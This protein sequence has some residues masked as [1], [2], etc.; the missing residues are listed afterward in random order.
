M[1]H[2]HT[3]TPQHISRERRKR[4]VTLP[5]TCSSDNAPFRLKPPTN[6][7]KAHETQ[8]QKAEQ[9]THT[10]HNTLVDQTQREDQPNTKASRTGSFSPRP[11]LALAAAGWTTPGPMPSRSGLLTVG[12]EKGREK[13]KRRAFGE[14]FPFFFNPALVSITSKEGAHAHTQT[15]GAVGAPLLTNLTPSCFATCFR[16]STTRQLYPH[17]LSYCACGMCWLGMVGLWGA[18]G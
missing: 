2:T 13:E 18:T 12:R 5:G 4:G 14:M 11:G 10:T 9:Q 6:P 16:R 1:L 7:D 3:H 17:S 15:W 8:L